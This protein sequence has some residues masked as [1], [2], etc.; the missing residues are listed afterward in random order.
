M[1]CGLFHINIINLLFIAE[2]GFIII[3]ETVYINFHSNL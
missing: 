1:R 2:I 3:G